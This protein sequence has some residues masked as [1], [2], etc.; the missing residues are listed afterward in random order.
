MIDNRFDEYLEKFCNDRKLTKEEALE[1][2]IVQE[3]KYYYEHSNVGGDF[4]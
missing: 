3:V 1:Y 2:A 4:L